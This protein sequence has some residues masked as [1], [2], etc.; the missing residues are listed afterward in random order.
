MKFNLFKLFLLLSM[1]CSFTSQA[2]QNMRL[3]ELIVGD[4][5]RIQSTLGMFYY[6]YYA[7][8]NDSLFKYSSLANLNDIKTLKLKQVAEVIL[9]S[10]V[11]LIA[12]EPMP[13]PMPEQSKR[14]DITENYTLKEDY[15]PREEYVQQYGD[16]LPKN[17][18]MTTQ[19]LAGAGAGYL[20]ALVG[21]IA[22]AFIG[23]VVVSSYS[24]DGLIVGAF[25][26]AIGVSIFSN[27][28]VVHQMGNTETI[29][30]QFWPTL[31]GTALGMVAGIFVYPVSPVVAAAGGVMAFNKSRK[32]VPPYR[33]H[34]PNNQPYN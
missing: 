12:N 6:G 4:S 21:G 11:V 10:R 19:I 23:D 16:A 26:G 20:G 22:G 13:E 28:A 24:Y 18:R 2:Q 30:G 25:I 1:G 14:Q 29:K 8:Q 9:L 15:T 34:K 17:Q 32:Q 5:V 3:S 7:G 33:S 27:A 31:A